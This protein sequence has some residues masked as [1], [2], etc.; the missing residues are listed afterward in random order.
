M[1]YFVL[2]TPE[3]FS[4]LFRALIVFPIF[5]PPFVVFQTR[6]QPPQP[7]EAVTVGLG[8]VLVLAGAGSG[9]T[10]TLVKR[11][12]YLLA[13]QVAPSKVGLCCSAEPCCPFFFFFFFSV[14]PLK[15]R[16]LPH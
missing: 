7:R 9:K 4:N 3:P 13:S 11:L 2:S 5:S 15:N 6:G 14:G 10:L 8:P 1:L 12:E 16:A